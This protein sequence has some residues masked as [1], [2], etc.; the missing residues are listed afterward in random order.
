LIPWVRASSIVSKKIPHKT[1]FPTF[2]KYIRRYKKATTPTVPK[3]SCLKD[4]K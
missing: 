2:A 3:I 1:S 4:R